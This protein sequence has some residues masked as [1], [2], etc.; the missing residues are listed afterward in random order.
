[1]DHQEPSLFEE[2]PAAFSHISEKTPAFENPRDKELL[3]IL[4][5]EREKYLSPYAFK[6]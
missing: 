1:M 6:T 2:F 4:R 5:D 3:T